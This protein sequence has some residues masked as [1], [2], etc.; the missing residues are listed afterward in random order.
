MKAL[1]SYYIFTKHIEP[2]NLYQCTFINNFSHQQLFLLLMKFS[3]NCFKIVLNN[4]KPNNLTEKSLVLRY[5][6]KPILL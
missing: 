3:E 5:K 1:V 4:S 2:A 6:Q